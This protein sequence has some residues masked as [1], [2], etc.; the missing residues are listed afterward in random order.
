[1]THTQY[2]FSLFNTF[3]NCK[4]SIKVLDKEILKLRRELMATKQEVLDAIAAE[5]AQVTEGLDSLNTQIQELKDQIAAGNAVTEADLDDIAAAV[6][7]I[8]IPPTA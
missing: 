8:F 5:K 3:C 6:N 2:S 4:E 1:M 7:E